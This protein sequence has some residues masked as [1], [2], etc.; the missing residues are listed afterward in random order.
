M[1]EKVVIDGRS[2]SQIQGRLARNRVSYT[3]SLFEGWSQKWTGDIAIAYRI[4]KLK[5]LGG[6][7]KFVV[8]PMAGGTDGGV[9]LK[10]A[11]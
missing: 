10:I 9:V 5:W 3:R 2:G 4:N 6:L 7:A 8:E 1:A 11:V